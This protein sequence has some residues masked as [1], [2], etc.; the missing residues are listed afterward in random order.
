MDILWL[1]SMITCFPW[2]KSYILYDYPINFMVFVRDMRHSE[3]TD[4]RVPCYI[5]TMV[6]PKVG[7]TYEYRHQRDL[8][9]LFAE[10][11]SSAKIGTTKNDVATYRSACGGHEIRCSASYG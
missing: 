4:E 5:M 7:L 2:N 9:D 8:K 10:V 3:D 11:A 6:L 1:P